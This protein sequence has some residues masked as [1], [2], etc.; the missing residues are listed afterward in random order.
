MHLEKQQIFLIAVSV[1]F[2]LIVFILGSRKK[3]I[4]I[5]GRKIKLTKPL[6]Y[7]LLIVT[8]IIIFIG[9]FI[10]YGFPVSGDVML[11]YQPQGKMAASG[12]APTRDFK[13]SYMFFFPYL[14][15]FID[16]LGHGN[17]LSIPLFLT[18]VSIF[19][20][21]ILLK[22][23]EKNFSFGESSKIIIVGFFAVPQWLYGI[24]YQ[25]DEILLLFFVLTSIW[26]LSK[27]ENVASG[28]FL[29]IGF[30]ITKS[31]FAL[32]ILAFILFVRQKRFLISLGATI[33]FLG[34]VALSMGF[35]P[36]EMLKAE[37]TSLGPPSIGN[38][39][40][41]YSPLRHIYSQYSFVFYLFLLTIS[42]LPLLILNT[43]KGSS[44]IDLIMAYTIV[45]SIFLCLSPKSL[46]PYRL[47]IYPFISIILYKTIFSQSKSKWIHLAWFYFYSTALSI[48]SVIYEHLIGMPYYAYVSSTVFSKTSLFFVLLLDTI[49]ILY[50]SMLVLRIIKATRR[51]QD[52]IV[53]S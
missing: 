12:L 5:G 23:L 4:T 33:I 28:I 29:A 13:T 41:M 43:Q 14:M 24:G 40:L 26:L 9:I 31:L 21:L 51:G 48:H 22:I 38:L 18:I 17:I 42:L 52:A 37:A 46:P 2:N 11:F 44:A 27:G 45:W 15:G 34:F 6:V 19:N 49:I 36:F 20:S 35:L 53:A 25:Q 47:L 16:I 39:F 3:A 30:W 32:T 10:I 1:I 8:P 50:E 7:T